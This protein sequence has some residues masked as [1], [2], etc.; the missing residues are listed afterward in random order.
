M[1]T[2]RLGK[3]ELM[4]SEVGFGGIPIIPLSI[5]EAVKVVRHCY[6]GGITFFDTANM[7]VDS[8]KKIGIAL[9]EVRDKVFLASK[10]LARDEAGA[11]NH[12]ER[13]LEQLNTDSIELYQ[14]HNVTSPEELEQVTAP[15]GALAAAEKAQREGK[16]RFIGF[17]SHSIAVAKDACRTGRFAT[18]QIPFNFIEYDPADEL[19]GIARE[20]DMG[21]I[22]MKPLGGGLLE[23][24]DL[25]FK[26]LQQYPEV[27]PIPGISKTAEIDEILTYY[28]SP[29]PLTD[30]DQHEIERIR[31]ELGKKFCHR[32]GYCLPCEQGVRIRDV[33]IF[34][35]VSRR[36]DRSTAIALVKDAM[37]TA[38]NCI[39]CGE[40]VE[41][42]P[43]DLEIPEMLKES[44]QLYNEFASMGKEG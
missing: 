19:F 17:T 43:Y 4:V 6:E 40:C 12:I 39:E 36:F 15:G 37:E 32:C 35:S 14:L 7:Y 33:L 16:I 42:C 38:E 8:E 27:L 34:K 23:R 31:L 26:F 21:I 24:A 44:F 28:E 2:K 29:A 41:R 10:T 18:V 22:A 1:K 13:S 9:E 5:E 20:L 25:C 11:R 3:T 30:A